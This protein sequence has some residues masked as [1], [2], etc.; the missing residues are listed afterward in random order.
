[1]PVIQDFYT[2]SMLEILQ[3]TEELGRHALHRRPYP[4]I[5]TN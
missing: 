3:Q 5:K 1:M 4:H 2:S